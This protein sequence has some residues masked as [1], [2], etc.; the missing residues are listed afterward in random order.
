MRIV[1][2]NGEPNSQS[3]FEQ[4]LQRLS[5]RLADSG[6][7]VNL[8]RLRG[9]D[10]KGCTGCF[11][12][13]VKTP[14]ECV[15]HD[16]S[17]KVCRAAINADLLLLASPLVMGFTTALLKRAFDQ[18]IC[19]LHPYFMIEDGEMHHR[20]RYQ[21]YPAFGLLLGAEADTDAEDIEIVT[22][23]WKRTAR[24]LK[25]T[26]VFTAVVDRTTNRTAEEVADELSRVA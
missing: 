22:T 6:H 15:R 1:I 20:P 5:G 24:N 4:Y 9:L 2:L 7:Q 26:V 21:N 10:L 18:M 8:L 11:G 17:E 19:L 14:G 13:W 12:C 23:M 16:D 25:S 3:E